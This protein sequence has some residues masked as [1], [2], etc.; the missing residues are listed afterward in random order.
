MQISENQ[1]NYDAKHILLGE[2][3]AAFNYLDRLLFT[4]FEMAGLA[5][6]TE[7]K[8]Q[9]QQMILKLVDFW[10]ATIFRLP[11]RQTS[12]PHNHLTLQRYLK[13]GHGLLSSLASFDLDEAEFL[14]LGCDYVNLLYAHAHGIHYYLKQS[15]GHDVPFPNLGALYVKTEGPL[16]CFA[17]SPE[18]LRDCAG[19]GDFLVLSLEKQRDK[20]YAEYIAR[21]HKSILHKSF[22]LALQ[23]FEKAIKIK[24]TAE[25]LTLAGWAHGF[26]G[27][28]E[29]ARNYCLKAISNNPDYGPPYND[30]GTYL[31]KEGRIDE[32][33]QWFTLAK[34]APIYDN[35]E[36]PYINAARVYLARGEYE[37]AVAEFTKAQMLAPFNT[38][39]AGT[40]EKLRALVD[41]NKNKL[42]SVPIS[43][44]GPELCP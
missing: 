35:R 18:H 13:A 28:F 16:P 36:F 39:I 23:H 6:Q 43:P 15:S 1:D 14:R 20:K 34:R 7:F 32:S 10:E 21:G 37:L 25:A 26:L 12:G 5:E 33:M 4:V 24:T 3:Q 27:Q 22:P 31:F 30:L 9:S 42:H 17:T 2:S 38:E 11:I 44:E 40:L 8:S 19:G 41:K 29:Q